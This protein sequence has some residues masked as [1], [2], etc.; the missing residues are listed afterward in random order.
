MAT[1]GLEELE[2]VICNESMVDPRALP[3]GHSYCGPPRQCLTG[4]KSLT[5]GLSCAICRVDNDLKPEVIK[6]LYGIRDYLIRK[7][8]TPEIPCSAHT[9]K[10]CSF[11]CNDCEMMICNECT[12]DKHDEHSVRNL[13][14]HLI[15]KIE[16][17]FGKSW[18][19]GIAKYR[20]NLEVFI[21][22]RNLEREKLKHLIEEMDKELQAAQLQA[23]VI[24]SYT[25]LET[26]NYGN[27]EKRTSETLP[28]LNLSNLDLLEFCESGSPRSVG[29]LEPSTQCN[30]ACCEISKQYESFSRLVSSESGCVPV[31]EN[32]STISQAD[33][34]QSQRPTSMMERAVSNASC[35][36]V[37]MYSVQT[38]DNQRPN[39]DFPS[40][41]SWQDYADSSVRSLA[42]DELS[43]NESF[44]CACVLKHKKVANWNFTI[45]V[46]ASLRVSQ[47]NP[48]VIGSSNSLFVCPFRFWLEAEL[49]HRQRRKRT[50]KMFRI[51]LRCDNNADGDC[52]ERLHQGNHRSIDSHI[53]RF[54][55]YSLR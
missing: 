33:A 9:S 29:K 40:N 2:C 34:L 23:S 50:E 53:V 37:G 14:K 49:I 48:L 30:T 13:K 27:E 52:H 11:W 44:S 42:D 47:R 20:G 1:G 39:S 10:E 3:C 35:S 7:Q 43:D 45:C 6:P 18:R 31:S 8:T 26:L 55:S 17:L 21:N 12:E 5:G 22:S 36:S 54:L 16:S 19:G 24:D 25:V 41:E 28:M 4:L 32:I 51:I 38:V 46:E 15:A